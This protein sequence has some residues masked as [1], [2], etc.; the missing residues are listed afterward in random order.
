MERLSNVS[1]RLKE[2][3]DIKGLTLSDLEKLINIPAQ[4]LNR[5]ELSQRV[6][7]IDTAIEIAEK[8]SINPLWLQGY[9]VGMYEEAP[10]LN[11]S[12]DAS[13][14]YEKLVE[15]LGLFTDEEW[16]KLMEYATLLITARQNQKDEK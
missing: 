7:K 8:L 5:Y 15:M 6:P 10:P 3:R 9:N 1:A 14:K 2:Y 16:N 13:I 12:E 11:L 4:T